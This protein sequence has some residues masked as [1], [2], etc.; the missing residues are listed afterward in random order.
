METFTIISLNPNLFDDFLNIINKG[1]SNIL[2]RVGNETFSN[3]NR[4]AVIER[5]N[6]RCYFSDAS[7]IGENNV[8]FVEYEI[9]FLKNIGLN[10]DEP[11]FYAIHYNSSK[12]LHEVIV[13]IASQY[14]VIICTLQLD[15]FLSKDYLQYVKNYPEWV[16]KGFPQRSI[17]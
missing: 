5:G 6:E 15:I 14:E 8:Y 13:S 2:I 3:S 7:L 12:L 1:I 16:K 9:P 11:Y 4:Q 17:D 10:P